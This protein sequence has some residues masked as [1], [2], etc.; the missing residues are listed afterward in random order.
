[1][2]M[3]LVII[4]CWHLSVVQYDDRLQ[5]ARRPQKRRVME[6]AKRATIRDRFNIPL[7]IN[8]VQYKAGVL[9]S[10]IKEV[11]S[12]AWKKD[13]ETGKK[14]RIYQRREYIKK[15]AKLLATELHLDADRLVDLIHSKSSLYGHIPYVIKEEITET[16]YYRLKMLE[17]NWQGIAAIRSPKRHYPHGKVGSELIGYMGAINREEYEG[18]MGEIKDLEEYLSLVDQGTDPLP[19]SGL[20]SHLEV[21]ARLQDLKEKAYSINDHVGKSG[22]EGQYEEELRGFHGKK[23][24]YSDARGNFL[25]ELPG[26]RDPL[27]GKRLLLSI[28]SELQEY[29]EELL[30]KNE[31]IRHARVSGLKNKRAPKEPWI[32]GGAIVA[33]DPNNGEVLALASTPRY[34]PNDFVSCGDPEK[35]KQKN[36]RIRCWFETESY[37]SGVWDQQYGLHREVFDHKYGIVEEELSLDWNVY[38]QKI[39]PPEN[40]V[41]STLK[42][43]SN[44]R[45]A[46]TI[47]RT[48]EIL[49]QLLE[50]Q[51]IYHLI[52]SLYSEDQ[53]HS[54]YGNRIGAVAK[55][56]LQKNID[57]HQLAINRHRAV[58]NKY[59]N[60]IPSNYDKVL[61]IDLCR[62]AVKE[63]LFSDELLQATGY[64]SLSHYRNASA[65][66]ARLSQVVKDMCQE[67][68]HEIDF[69]QWREENEKSYLK[70]MRK[71]EKEQKRYAKPYLDYI[72]KK[73]KEL[74][75]SFW[76]RY[77]WQFL[78][79]FLTGEW[80][81]FHPDE[82]IYPYLAYFLQWHQELEQGAHNRLHWVEAYNHLR[83]ALASY[84]LDIA[85]EY[86]QT[87]RSFNELERPLL[88]RY[89]QLR[90]TN[91]VQYEKHL[92]AAFY[93][94]YGYGFARSHAYRQATTLG[95]IFKIVT[96][97]EALTQQYKLLDNPY[98]S[99]QRLNPLTM[100]DQYYK[101]GKDEFVGQHESG[102][103]IPRY[104]K[105][106]RL[107]RSLS[108]NIGKLDITTA[109]ERSSNP[110]FALLAG[111]FMEDC[112]DLEKTARLFSY[113]E[114]T[115]IKLPMEISGKV[116]DDLAEN[117]TGLYSFSIGQHSLVVTPLQTAVMLSAIANGGK[118]V[119]P[120]I[121]H[122]SV[123]R[124]PN[125]K[126]EVP[127]CKPPF[128][129]QECYASVGV[130]FP[131]FTAAV[132]NSR[133]S[134][135]QR[136]YT[137]VLREIFMPEQVRKILIEGMSRVVGRSQQIAIGSLQSL[138]RSDPK[139]IRDLISLKGQLVGK[140]STA[141]SVENIDL[142]LELGTNKYNHL[143]FGG[144]AFHQDEGQK[145]T[146]VFKDKYGNPELVV[147]VYL[148]YGAY[149]KDT[150]P[151]AAQIVNKWRAI[152]NKHSK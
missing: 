123:G 54:L 113:G 132:E 69:K 85:I 67:L 78:I 75:Q 140:T 135:I 56:R 101:I 3:I 60:K 102:K 10:H 77:R 80:M 107:P 112:C 66:M 114:K 93:P 117:R 31:N 151:V 86:F 115:G 90:K 43:H 64:Q 14:V 91:G 126:D 13:P 62:L 83:T 12:I 45:D 79:V 129:Y 40:P 53:G 4:R 24:Y 138:Y 73:E 2:A 70:E 120:K 97:Y 29:A 1:M 33:M 50:P 89:R 63:D 152:K 27:S 55:D 130:D 17:K 32:K 9:Y 131:L 141:E 144:I 41:I 99:T 28:S 61:Y 44:I 92:A 146:H 139:A 65:A 136:Y 48:V 116:P 96:A 21:K 150:M 38:L 134:V 25:R 11:P 49:S 23:S 19:P 98:V 133:K 122:L 26:G 95:S 87:L 5:F 88:G 108:R 37:L 74:F 58:L 52:N 127:I 20:N 8:K 124:I 118:I 57:N 110:Y 143:W 147:V 111:D 59:L 18:V 148:R 82:N 149:G 106:G 6:P 81:E 94:T 47:Q 105:G 142:D 35:K 84:D 39:L 71:I 34:D 128:D 121:I 119:E 46:I 15:L 16:E 36:Q 51:N 104:Y 109:I 30:I 103:A 137:K 76:S 42:R 72:D 125:R 145:N 68:Y 100:H 7:A 22:I